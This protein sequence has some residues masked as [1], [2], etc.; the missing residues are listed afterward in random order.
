MNLTEHFTVE[1]LT[2]SETAIRLGYNNNPD[3]ETLE[4]LRLLCVNVLEPLRNILNVPIKIN[5][6]YRS[7]LTNAAVGGV[8]T[9]QHCKGE[10]AD[11]VA[12]GITI[13]DYYNK[14][15]QLINDG[16]IIADQV[17]Y[18]YNSWVH[19]S[20]NKEHNRKQFLIKETGKPY[21]ADNN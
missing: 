16:K 7:K 11:T 20:Y 12:I 13:K 10:A 19:I 4:N 18:E 6:G 8:V 15:K 2:Y 1:E 9:S 17:I 5:S 21:I 14:V 3:E